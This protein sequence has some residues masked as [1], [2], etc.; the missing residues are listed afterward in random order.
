MYFSLLHLYGTNDN[1]RES[2]IMTRNERRHPERK[3]RIYT[4]VKELP[5]H[6]QESSP[7]ISS[8]SVLIVKLSSIPLSEAALF[9][10][11]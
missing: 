10:R 11:S 7:F 9:L 4:Q 2:V 6:T 3:R 8:Y 1:F 5:S